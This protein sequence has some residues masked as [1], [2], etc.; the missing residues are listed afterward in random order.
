VTP[1]TAQ[2]GDAPDARVPTEA[3]GHPSVA[4]VT[5]TYL[6]VAGLRERGWTDVRRLR[7]TS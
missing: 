1:P 5:A 7:E 3:A 2:R 6:T 4:A